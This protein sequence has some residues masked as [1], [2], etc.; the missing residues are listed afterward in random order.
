MY[1]ND[2]NEVSTK[3][4]HFEGNQQ[5]LANYTQTLHTEWGS[6]IQ[7]S[8]RIASIFFRMQKIGYRVGIKR[9]TATKRLGQLL[10]GEVRYADLANRVIKRI[11]S[12]FLPGQE[13]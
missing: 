8:Q 11:S 13:N 3:I 4:D 1:D 12:S 2:G 7:W 10:A 9:P 5:A 6:D